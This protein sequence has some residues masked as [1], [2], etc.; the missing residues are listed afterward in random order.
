[1]ADEGEYMEP[2][3]QEPDEEETLVVLMKT[4]FQK[5][6]KH[7]KIASLG[8][9]KE[10]DLN[11][12]LKGNPWF[13][14]NAWLLVKKW[15]RAEDQIDKGLD[16]VETKMQIWDLPEHCKT[17]KLGEKIA[18]CMGDVVS[19][20]L[21]E[22][23]KDQVR[24]IKATVNMNINTPFM[25]GTN[26]GSMKDGLTWVNF[27]YERLPTFCYY[28]GKAGQEENN[29]GK[30]KQDEERGMYKSKSLG[31]WIKADITGVRVDTINSRTN[32]KQQEENKEEG[33]RKARI[34]EKLMEKLACLSIVDS[35]ESDIGKDN[36]QAPAITL[37][38]TS[39]LKRDLE[40]G[41]KK[42]KE[43]HEFIRKKTIEINKQQ[44]GQTKEETRLDLEMSVIDNK[45]TEKEANWKDRKKKERR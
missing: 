29:C 38:G 31:P 14:R 41:I 24:F 19:C 37:P 34:T 18:A 23:G 33:K 6:S 16:K 25:K 3:E 2:I 7:A 10:V 11:R 17:P 45:E 4:T 28:C 44:K 20:K 30:G 39:S 5:V 42:G 15:E 40:D 32:K 13:F 22:A 1:M 27:K 26:V 12:V 9:Y 43:L 21:F 8:S 36:S 35:F